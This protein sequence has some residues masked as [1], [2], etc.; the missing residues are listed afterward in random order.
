MKHVGLEGIVCRPF[1]GDKYVGNGERGPQ[2]RRKEDNLVEP[3]KAISVP[4][5]LLLLEHESGFNKDTRPRP[6]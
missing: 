6:T 4:C 5:N 1:N 3:S 2:L